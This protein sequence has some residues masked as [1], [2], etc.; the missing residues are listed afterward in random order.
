MKRIASLVLL[1]FAAAVAHATVTTGNLT[2]SFTCTGSIGPFPFTFPISAPTALTVTQ[3]GTVIPSTGYTVT[4]VNNKYDNG[5]SVRLV[6]ACPSSETLVI[7]RTTPLT[8]GTVF[9]N[10]M[11]LP[12][13][14]FENGLDKLTE[15]AQEQE[16]EL[17]IPI[18]VTSVPSGSCSYNNQVAYFI[19]GGTPYPQ[20]TCVNGT[21]TQTGGGGSGGSCVAGTCVNGY[22]IA[23]KSVIASGNVTSNHMVLNSE[24]S[25]LV[26]PFGFD[27]FLYA[28]DTPLNG[29]LSESGTSNWV[30]TGSGGPTIAS[31]S[32]DRLVNNAPASAEYGFYATI[33]NT[34]T[35]GGTPP[36]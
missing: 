15:I 35:P 3:N 32:N 21:W 1:I 19:S 10:N 17:W 11:P 5:G 36:P 31:I 18:Y 6:T 28:D 16:T 33:K 34:S 9:T 30:V 14:S 22:D 24:Q 23:P 2:V 8:Q 7:Q 25:S 4:P 26:T 20:Y 29:L 12:M 27:H 13:T